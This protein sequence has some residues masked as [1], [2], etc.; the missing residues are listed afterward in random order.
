MSSITNI[1]YSVKSMNG[2]ITI[3][4]GAGGTMEDGVITCNEL[5]VPVINCNEVQ[6]YNVSTNYNLFTTAPSD[7]NMG[8]VGVVVYMLSPIVSAMPIIAGQFN[9]NLAYLNNID[10]QIIN[11]STINVSNVNVDTVTVGTLNVGTVT[12]GTVIVSTLFT[13]TITAISPSSTVVMYNNVTSGS[14]TLGSDTNTSN[15]ELRTGG[16]CFL[17]PTASQMNIGTQMTLG[18]ITLGNN[19]SGGPNEIRL[20]TLGTMNLGNS[21][22]VIEMGSNANI[23]NLITIG[24]VSSTTNISGTTINLGSNTSSTSIT[25]VG[26]FQFLSDISGNT[27]NIIDG[28][29]VNVSATLR[30]AEKLTAGFIRIGTSITTGNIVIGNHNST[31]SA[32]LRTGGTLQLGNRATVLN[33]GATS[34][35]INAI[36]IGNTSSTIE[37]E[38]LNISV[39]T[40]NTSGTINIGTGQLLSTDRINIGN[41]NTSGLGTM[42]LGLKT[43]NIGLNST[44]IQIGNS[45]GAGVGINIGNNS[46]TTSIRGGTIDMGDSTSSFLLKTPITPT[47]DTLYTAF[48]GTPS[49]CIGNYVFPDITIGNFDLTS[50]TNKVGAT[51]TNLEVGVWL[52]YWNALFFV[53][54]T[55]AVITSITLNIGESSGGTNVLATVVECATITLA[56]GR[57]KSYSV[58]Q[59]YTNVS[60]AQDIFFSTTATF[61]GTLRI[62]ST[63]FSGSNC[64]AVRLS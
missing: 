45:M 35:T 29:A 32:E 27:M 8:N 50:T 21:A 46:I 25:N 11:V 49:G 7:I 64:K 6:P 39:G 22:S 61:T 59:V 51:F 57:T 56:V 44:S 15:L 47:Y 36:T 3:D 20:R 37:L 23:S 60:S 33:M 2:I 42:N 26:T 13:D 48:A 31:D 54:T 30:I 24:N 38:G 19:L 18:I 43:I 40:S 58:T 1:P 16:V 63:S 5:D 9:S 17:G 53:P 4:D 62:L 34:N 12:A 14:I 55:N 28:S 41:L 10:S 52:F